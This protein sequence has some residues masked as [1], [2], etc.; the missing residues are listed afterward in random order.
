MEGRSEDGAD[1]SQ[2]VNQS[3]NKQIA[4]LL[5]SGRVEGRDRPKAGGMLRAQVLACLCSC[6]TAQKLMQ[7]VRRTGWQGKGRAGQG[8][9]ACS[10]GPGP[11]PGSWQTQSGAW[12]PAAV[13]C[14]SM[15]KAVCPNKT[16]TLEPGVIY[17]D[18]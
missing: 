9:A 13:S 12:S 2:S 3:V 17:L 16:S 11:A 4:S 1:I 18:D 14:P 15:S 10:V 7:A 6:S 5:N 8:R